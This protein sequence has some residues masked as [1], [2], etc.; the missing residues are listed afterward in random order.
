MVKDRNGTVLASA[1]H[2]SEIELYLEHVYMPGDVIT[3][4]GAKHFFARMDRMLEWG[5]IFASEGI[6]NWT[7]PSGEHRLAYAPGMF[8]TPF[9]IIAVRVWTKQDNVRRN[10]ACNPADLRGDTDF[11]PHCNANVET[12]NEACFCARNV[13]DG[14]RLNT[15]H[16]VWPYQSWGVGERTDA[17]CQIDLGRH[18][19]VDAVALT[20]RADF[21]HDAFWT[22]GRL[23]FDYSWEMRIE[24]RKT[25]ERQ[26]FLLP[27]KRWIRRIRLDSLIKSDDPSAFPALR[28]IEIFGEDGEKQEELV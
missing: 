9:H 23:F 8:E 4:T 14:S 12:R 6:M 7:V 21:P 10:L 3:V 22:S 20:L 15:S 24:L 27:E 1:A 11:F 17:W 25:G 26:L 2:E 19:R 5:E 28:Q 18:A 13:I 16:G